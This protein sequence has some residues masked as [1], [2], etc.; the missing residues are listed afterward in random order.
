MTLVVRLVEWLPLRKPADLDGPHVVRKAARA[1]RRPEL[2][3]LEELVRL[4]GQVDA[5][6]PGPRKKPISAR[7]TISKPARSAR[8]PR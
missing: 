2:D 4:V 5:N 8:G 3:P 7:R 1:T 6:E